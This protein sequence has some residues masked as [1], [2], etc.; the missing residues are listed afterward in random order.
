MKLSRPV[1]LFVLFA[2]NPA[3]AEEGTAFVPEE[4][5][6]T[7]GKP[8]GVE[9]K[10][11]AALNLTLSDNRNVIGQDEGTTLTFGYK[12]GAQLDA[13]HEGHELRNRAL[14]AAT[15]AYSPVIEDFRKP[16]DEVSYEAIYLY[17]IVDPFGPFV[18]AAVQ[19]SM[20]QGFDARRGPTTYVV[21]RSD[22]TTDSFTLG[23]P[24]DAA[25][26]PV[27]CT[28]RLPLTEPWRPT[29]LK[30]SVGLFAQA[31]AEQWLSVETRAGVG[32]REVLAGGQLAIKDNGDTPEVELVELRD[33]W[34]AGG[35]GVLELWGDVEEKKV[36]Y[37]ASLEV[38]VPF[39]QSDAP[40][41]DDKSLVDYTVVEMKAA[42][43]FKLVAWATLDYEI[44]ALR[45][46]LVLDA[47]QVRNQLLLNFGVAAGNI[48]EG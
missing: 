5:V 2:S 48:P 35:E 14:A 28:R 43:S 46:P 39:A 30:Q 38:L 27:P 32:A 18:R 11:D 24:L 22:G 44:G 1:L 42:L 40:V 16:R 45:E 23:C 6:G 13:R 34:Q 37:R 17:H 41:G 10:V 8:D 3:L 12:T 9:W 29:R 20:L 33:V 47:W 4:K 19:T 7:G 25:G 31:L 21:E 15:I 26:E 36:T